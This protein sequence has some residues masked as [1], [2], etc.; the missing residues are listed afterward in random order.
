MLPM[1]RDKAALTPEGAGCDGWLHVKPI[2]DVLDEIGALAE[3]ATPG[4]WILFPSNH[5][6]GDIAAVDL[7]STHGACPRDGAHPEIAHCHECVIR[8]AGQRKDAAFIAAARSAVPAL[9]AECR[10]LR[11]A[12]IN[13]EDWIHSELL[14]PDRRLGE[15]P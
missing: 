2:P 9:V 1:R 4:P 3:A 8:D 13:A 14:R 6:E 15:K 10:L 11:E 5:S 7:C 12:L